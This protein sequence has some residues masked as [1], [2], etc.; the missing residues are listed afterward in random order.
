MSFACHEIGCTNQ[1]AMFCNCIEAN[2][3]SC[4][5]HVMKH[6]ESDEGCQ[7]AAMPMYKKINPEIKLKD[8]QSLHGLKESLEKSQDESLKYI[9]FAI[10]SL[11]SL[12]TNVTIYYEKAKISVNNMIEKAENNEKEL[13]VPG[14]T[15]RIFHTETFQKYM[16]EIPKNFPLMLEEHLENALNYADSLKSEQEFYNQPEESEL[17]FTSNANLD[18]NLYF[19]KTNT[20]VFVEV[21]TT[22]FIMKE[23]LVNISENQGSLTSICQIPG[24]KVFTSGGYDPFLNCTYLIDLNNKS[25]ESLPKCRERSLSSA[26]YLKGAVYIFGGFSSKGLLN[27]A[28][29]FI[30]QSKRWISLADL[31]IAQQDTSVL[32]CKDFVIISTHSANCL[33]SYKT[34]TNSYETL[35][36]GVIS[37]SYNILIRN[38]RIYYLLSGNNIF[39]SSEGMID[40]WNKLEIT[41]NAGYCQNTSKPINRGRYAY[42]CSSHYGKVFRFGFDDFSLVEIN[43]QVVNGLE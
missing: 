32:P 17:D 40:K 8:I 10:N 23:Y 18:Q 20:K 16:D 33:F 7:H 24:D 22:D 5:D 19:F 26:T 11:T 14:F 29:K 43:C 35:A 4:T 13:I 30:L 25:V 36:L 37:H 28:D 31:P 27:N 6:F 38:Q 39:V 42:F 3:Y 34:S 41:S 2:V 21:S 12:Q 1:P 15:P 9:K